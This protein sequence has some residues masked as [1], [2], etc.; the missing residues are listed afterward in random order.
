MKLP[1]IIY[2]NGDLQFYE[3]L[4]KAQLDIEPTDVRNNQ[5]IIYDSGGSLLNPIVI[6]D[7]YYDIVKIYPTKIVKKT[8]LI[9]ILIDFF[10]KV[11]KD[12]LIL[13]TM[14]LNELV[15]LGETLFKIKIAE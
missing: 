1:I 6:G 12:E 5:Y 11:G 10:A 7:S 13:K 8:E 15:D 3:S 4:E 2:E 9:K 14:E